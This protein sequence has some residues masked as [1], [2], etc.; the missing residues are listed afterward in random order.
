MKHDTSVPAQH[1]KVRDADRSVPRNMHPFWRIQF[2]RNHSKGS[3]MKTIN[4]AQTAA[5]AL[6]ALLALSACAAQP[7]APPPLKM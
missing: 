2:S 1:L 4:K 6:A 5:A 3:T 7:Q